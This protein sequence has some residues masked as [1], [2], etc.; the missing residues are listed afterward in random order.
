MKNKV[1]F[2]LLAWMFLLSFNG[3][4]A[5]FIVDSSAFQAGG[6]IPIQ[7]TCNSADIS[8]PIRWIDAVRRAKSY[9]I[10][11]T[12]PDAPNGDWVHWVL[13]NIPGKLSELQQGVSAP[14][15]AVSGINSYGVT[16]YKGPCPDSGMHHYV[17]KVWALDTYLPLDAT[18][19]KDDVIKAI[20]GHTLA[21]N[22]LIATYAK[23]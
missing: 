20:E 9:A 14:K 17:F 15:G 5:S 21:M 2:S 22:Q 7:Y 12:D 23:Q 1:Y 8:P 11:M 13:F 16:G 4:A 18:A 10:I 6:A 3:Y 19:T